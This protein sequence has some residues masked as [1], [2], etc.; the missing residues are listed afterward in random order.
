MLTV[1][2]SILAE[3]ESDANRPVVVYELELASST[4]RYAPQALT[5]GGNAY[6]ALAMR[7]TP[8]S[9]Q[10]AFRV[11]EVAVTFS[12]VTNTLRGYF[13]PEDQLTGYPLTVR[14]LMRDSAG[15]LLA[16]SL[17]LFR[18]L[19][20]RPRRI[21]EEVFEV[22]AVG[23]LKGWDIA[24]PR[25]RASTWCPWVFADG[26]HCPYTS[27]TTAS[28][29]GT[30]STAVQVADASNLVVGRDITIGTGAKVA[31]SAISGVDVTLA[32][33]RT[34]SV[35]DAVAYADCNRSWADCGKR[36]QRHR[37]GGFLASPNMARLAYVFGGF[38]V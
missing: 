25:R 7:Q 18:G 23:L 37:F 38:E 32:A 9:E 20:E 30:N 17:V 36:A 13:E 15:A 12:N 19:M 26:V 35:S 29:A 28:N 11:P 34:W 24:I 33:A 4:L 1:P 31:I 14:L 21:S 5:W 16:D 10:M 3:L 27:T 22:R 6:S 2:A 8:I